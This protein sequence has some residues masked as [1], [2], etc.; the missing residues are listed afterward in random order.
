VTKVT[1]QNETL[2]NNMRRDLD[3]PHRPVADLD[4]L[5]VDQSKRER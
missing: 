5:F 2:I 4:L 1:K 3:F